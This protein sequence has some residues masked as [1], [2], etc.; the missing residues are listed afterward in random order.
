MMAKTNFRFFSAKISRTDEFDL[1]DG[2]GAAPSSTL[3]T[4]N[5]HHTED[6]VAKGSAANHATDTHKLANTDEEPQRPAPASVNGFDQQCRPDIRFP[7]RKIGTE[8]FERSFQKSWFTVYKWL[9][10]NTERDAVLCFSCCKA[11]EKG[12]RH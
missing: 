9:H 4:V 6:S 11:L 10:Y 8:T 1:E 2:D 7:G 3:H 5:D 12:F